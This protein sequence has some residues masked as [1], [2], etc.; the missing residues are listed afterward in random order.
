MSKAALAIKILQAG[1][2][3]SYLARVGEPT[4]K[5]TPG[6]FSSASK[7]FGIK[8]GWKVKSESRE[9]RYSPLAARIQVRIAS[10]IPF[11]NKLRRHVRR[12]VIHHDYFEVRRDFFQNRQKLRANSGNILLLVESGQNH[13]EFHNSSF[14]SRISSIFSAT[15]S[16]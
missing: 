8:L 12:T 14:S 15:F 9:T 13:G 16:P 7:S 4:T 1:M 3:S 11:F 6:F 10:A 5:S 2:F